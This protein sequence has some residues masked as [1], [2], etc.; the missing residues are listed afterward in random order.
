[1]KISEVRLK[2]LIREEVEGNDAL[3]RAIEALSDKIEN[4]DVSIDYTSG[5]VKR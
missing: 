4:L 5:L 1:M 2:Q 3:L